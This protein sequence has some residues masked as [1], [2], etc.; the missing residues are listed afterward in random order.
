MAQAD[1]NS[2]G[3][4]DELATPVHYRPFDTRYT[5]YTGNSRGFICMPRFDVMRHML[6]GM[7]VG[8][9]TCRQQSDSAAKWNRCGVIRTILDECTISNKTKEINYLYPLYTYPSEEQVAQGLYQ[10]GE[11]QPNL[12]PNFTDNLAGSLG[13][14]FIP[15]GRG[16]L[17]ETFGPEDVLHYI[18]AVFHSPSYRERYDQFLRADFPRVP[19]TDDLELFRVLGRFGQ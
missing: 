14:Q 18:Y 1:L 8:L 17:Q 3:I 11:R 16:D 13:L 9:V 19:L 2:P 6:A 7:N 12:A 4:R 15:D 5:Y 10:P